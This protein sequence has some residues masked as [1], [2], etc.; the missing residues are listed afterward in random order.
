MSSCLTRDSLGLL[1]GF[2]PLIFY[3]HLKKKIEEENWHW[4]V[5]K[6]FFFSNFK[7]QKKKKKHL[8]DIFFY[9]IFMSRDR[10]KS[11]SHWAEISSQDHFKIRASEP[12][13]HDPTKPSRDLSYQAKI[14]AIECLSRDPSH[15]IEIRANNRVK[16]RYLSYSF[17][18]KLKNFIKITPCI[19]GRM[20]RNPKLFRYHSCIS[21]LMYK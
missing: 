17:V 6:F 15:W 21:I 1:T 8:W 20:L 19:W 18:T 10:A 13:S 12:L 14:Q 4:P 3:F 2:D 9:F 11:S 5:R 7:I 16:P